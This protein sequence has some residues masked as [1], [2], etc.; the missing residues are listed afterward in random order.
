[1]KDAIKEFQN[2]PIVKMVASV[3]LFYYLL[4]AAGIAWLVYVLMELGDHLSSYF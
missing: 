1:M 4:G 3:P 2:H